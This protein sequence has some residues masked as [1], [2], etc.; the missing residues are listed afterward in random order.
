M[1][2]IFIFSATVILLLLQTSCICIKKCCT[3]EQIPQ[4]LIT[5]SQAYNLQTNYRNKQEQIQSGHAAVYA[6]D[7]DSFW[8]S[9]EKLKEYICYAEEEASKNGKTVNGFRIYMGAYPLNSISDSKIGYN[10]VFIVPT[11]KKTLPPVNSNAKMSGSDASTETIEGN[12]SED[13]NSVSPLDY[14]GA[15]NPPKVF[16]Q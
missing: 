8:F 10:T 2:R 7:V 12:N 11:E 16:R 3:P 14:A 6:D 1:K 13:I 15:G 9:K 5:N 4:G